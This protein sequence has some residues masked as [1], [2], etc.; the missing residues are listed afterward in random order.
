MAQQAADLEN[1]DDCTD[2]RHK[3]RYYRVRHQANVL[4]NTKDTKNNLEYTGQYHG[5]EYKAG[6][7]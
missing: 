7:A 5:G 2:A 4:A 3:A 1:D 6:V